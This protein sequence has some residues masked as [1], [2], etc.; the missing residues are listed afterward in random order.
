MLSSKRKIILYSSRLKIKIYRGKNVKKMI[1]IIY[2]YN[3]LCFFF[4][5]KKNTNS[6]NPLIANKNLKM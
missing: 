3:Y 6:L 2:I 4:P 5:L 1:Y